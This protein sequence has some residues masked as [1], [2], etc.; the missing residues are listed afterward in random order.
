MYVGNGT[1]LIKLNAGGNNCF[2]NTLS[3]I[4]YLLFTYSRWKQQNRF[5][6]TCSLTTRHHFSLDLTSTW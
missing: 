4:Y 1:F 2:E 5:R 3:A 6:F